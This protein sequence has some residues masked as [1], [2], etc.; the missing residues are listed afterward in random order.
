MKIDTRNKIKRGIFVR[1]RSLSLNMVPAA[2]D[3]VN[4]TLVDEVRPTCSK[5]QWNFHLVQMIS[6][7]FNHNIQTS[8]EIKKLFE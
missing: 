3:C 4:R 8:N 6:Y 5:I 1:V 2:Q 7:Q